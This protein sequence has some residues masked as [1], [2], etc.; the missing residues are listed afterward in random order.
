MTAQAQT[1]QACDVMPT[2]AMA[3]ESVTRSYYAC[4]QTMW[5]VVGDPTRMP[6]I[7]IAFGPTALFCLDAVA[8]V[9]VS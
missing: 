3:N 9:A 7:N 4:Y 1:L 5:A 2:N 8:S 6:N